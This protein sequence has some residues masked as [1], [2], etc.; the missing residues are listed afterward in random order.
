MFE[1]E[2]YFSGIE[3]V[4]APRNEIEDKIAAIWQEVLATHESFGIETNYFEIGGNSLNA[5]TL[6]SK[7]RKA[8][9]TELS[10]QEFFRSPTIAELAQLLVEKVRGTN[11][12][13][14]SRLLPLMP[15]AESSYYPL[16]SAQTRVF[17]LNQFEPQSTYYNA[18]IVMQ[19]EGG[20]V[21]P[22]RCESVFRKLVER[23]E[24][25]RTRFLFVDGKPMQQVIHASEVPV[26]VEVIEALGADDVRLNAEIERF[27]RPFDLTQ[28][29]LFRVGLIRRTTDSYLFVIDIHHIISDGASMAVLVR[30]FIAF[31]EGRNLPEMR[32]QYK[33]YANWQ[34]RL[35]ETDELKRQEQYWLQKFEAGVPI[36]NLPTDKP[37]PELKS[38]EGRRVAFKADEELTSKLQAL[39]KQ[40]NTSLFMVLLA[41]YNVFLH[42][43]TAQ[44]K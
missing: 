34:N 1:V 33:D 35:L 19:I 42:K 24:S 27:V 9:Q 17:I 11:A 30:E 6:V 3:E 44:E 10:L 22:L 28:A 2:D 21:E 40:T 36:L 39:A 15:V 12:D 18:T 8:F 23:H 41:A 37:R 14:V 25:L 13:D 7:I 16:S 5:A 4:T 26:R 31:Y 20:L 29:P 32:V 38:V 43:L